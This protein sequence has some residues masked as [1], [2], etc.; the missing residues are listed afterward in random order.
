MKNDIRIDNE[1]YNDSRLKTYQKC[2][3]Y[4]GPV[5]HTQPL[6]R[7]ANIF[8]RL[9]Q[10]NNVAKLCKLDTLKHDTYQK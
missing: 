9:L 4:K 5:Q 8:K 1:G 2:S 10:G 6:T 3:K 7:S